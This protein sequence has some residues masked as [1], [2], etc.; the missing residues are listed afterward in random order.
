[1][2]VRKSQYPAFTKVL[3]NNFINQYYHNVSAQKEEAKDLPNSK[4]I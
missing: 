2:E 4:Q 3:N 1:M